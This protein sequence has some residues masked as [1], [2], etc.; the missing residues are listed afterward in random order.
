MEVAEFNRSIIEEFRANGG[1]V[2]GPFEGATLA[3]L[4]TTGAKTGRPHTTPLVYLADGDRVLV[5]ATNSG[6]PSHPQW[7]TNL[8][9]DNRV[10]VEIGTETYEATA[11]ALHGEE[12]AA[13]YAEQARRHPAFAEYQ[14]KTDREIPVVALYRADSDQPL[15]IGDLLVNVHRSLR[16]D[17]AALRADVESYLSNG[18][19]SGAARPD[20]AAQLRAHCTAFCGALHEHH[21]GEETE[22]FPRLQ[23]LHPELAPV[24]ERLRQEHD[25]VTGMRRD[26]QALLD[27]IDTADPDQVRTKLADVNDQLEAHYAYEEKELFDALNAVTAGEWSGSR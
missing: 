25:A 27:D 13:K 2:G 7:F 17:L 15:G 19:A 11:I 8:L 21:Q 5:F 9:A 12:R 10:T 1:A 24:L 20:L 4:T 16:Q 6:A 3:L 18:Q 22:G 14:E 26:L 23:R